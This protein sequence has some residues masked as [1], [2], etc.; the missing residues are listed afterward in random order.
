MDARRPPLI[1]IAAAA[2]VCAAAPA[3]AQEPETPEPPLTW[4]GKPAAILGGVTTLG[5]LCVLKAPRGLAVACAIPVPVTFFAPPYIHGGRGNI[6]RALLSGAL[7][8]GALVAFAQLHDHA[9]N[10]CAR[11]EAPD[12]CDPDPAYSV[13]PFAAAT[14]I[15]A[16]LL[17]W[18]RLQIAPTVTA[19]RDGASIGIAGRF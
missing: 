14:A 15:D 4:Y 10:E 7:Q 19:T 3:R 17:S 6:G 2:L 8:L 12:D 5:M 1:A 18:D 16:G 13:L 9:E 11:P